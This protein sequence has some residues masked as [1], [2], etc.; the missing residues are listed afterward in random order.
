MKTGP[1]DPARVAASLAAAKR[2]EAQAAARKDALAKSAAQVPVPTQPAD[3]FEAPRGSTNR[4]VER[5]GQ[6]QVGKRATAWSVESN[7]DSKATRSGEAGRNGKD[8]KAEGE[9]SFSANRDTAYERETTYQVRPSTGKTGPRGGF[10]NGALNKVQ[11]WGDKLADMGVRA[12]FKGA[13]WDTR[14]LSGLQ[15]ENGSGTAV[16]AGT[17]GS[18][19]FSIGTDGLKA[20][21]DRA[22]SAGAYAQSNGYV[23][24]KHGTAG[25]QASAKAEAAASATGQASVNLNGVDASFDAHVGVSAQASVSGQVESRPLATVGGVELTVG[26]EGTASVSAEAEAHATASA[27]I[28]RDPPTAVLEGEVGASAVAKAEVEGSIHAGPFQA[29]GTAYVSAGAEAVAGAGVSYEDGKFTLNLN[30]GAAVGIGA[31]ASGSVTVDVEMIGEMAHDLAD[32]N[33]DGKLGIDD[34][35]I[36]GKKVAHGTVNLLDA[37]NDGRIG[38]ADVAVIGQNVKA[39]VATKASDVVGNVRDAAS[40]VVGNVRDAASNVADNVKDRISGAASWVRGA[41]GR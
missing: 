16:T 25:Y 15:V 35:F 41:F 14:D 26:A 21:F 4:K 1:L 29:S 38:R 5:S 33:N 6:E 18:S 22:A 27:K 19:S 36:I 32:A 12:E 9:V 10:V 17:A 3:G 23:E 34:A 20:E 39:A 2:N 7:R 30:L 24:G 40:N 8:W 31:G 28:T 13:Q 37:N 11:D